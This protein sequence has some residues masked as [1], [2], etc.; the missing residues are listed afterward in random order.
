MSV[1]DA[2][3]LAPYRDEPKQMPSGAPGKHG[4]L[5]MAFARRGDRSV[6]A[7]LYREAPLLVQQALYWDEHLPGLPGVYIITTSGC[8]LQG[9]RF[10]VSVTVGTGA[11][12]HVTTQSAT[13]IHQMDANFAAQSQR[14]A[15]ADH[16]YL[17]LVPGPVIPHRHSRFITHTL[18]TVAES[19]TLLNVELVQPG[20]KHHGAGELFEFDL[21]SSA[22]TVSRPDGISLFTEKLVAEPWRHPVRQAG[23]MGTFD[24]FANVTL[25]TPR[26]RAD[27]IFE[28]VIPG[29]DASTGCVAGA[30][31]LPNDAGL[32]YKVLGM[33]T[34]PVKAK[35]RAFW[36]LVRQQVLGAPIPAARPWG[37]PLLPDTAGEEIDMPDERRH[38]SADLEDY[39]VLDA[40]D[41]L[42]GV[43]GDDPLDRGVVTPD[44]W[45]AAIRFGTTASEQQ[46]GESL[47]QA[48]AEEEADVSLD[49][50]D[51]PDEDLGPDENATDEDV[52]RYLLDDGP[53]PRAGRLVDEDEEI[54]EEGENYVVARDGRVA[55]DAGIDGGG[56]TA[57]EA[58]I[59]VVDGGTDPHPD[60]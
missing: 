31:R 58:A 40:S 56:A 1:L 19:A 50:D 25:I 17:E 18:A 39:E 26:R 38:E 9:D 2:P 53:D 29:A 15:L 34:E 6:L 21:Y 33:E 4:V 28:Q 48:L 42:D 57:E 3:E 12:A 22:L 55:Y 35:V 23:V 11:M 59:H 43:P 36:A 8:V 41:T 30:S 10:D 51:G 5:D 45:S 37:S 47:D 24:V 14:L 60:D 32:V 13:K 54:D 49:S 16:A 20:R 27:E 46:T 52:G 7:H 44:R